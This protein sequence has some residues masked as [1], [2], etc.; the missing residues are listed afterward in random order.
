[1]KGCEG[2]KKLWCAV[3]VRGIRYDS[4]PCKVLF[5]VL[6]ARLGRGLG[7]VEVLSMKPSDPLQVAKDH[8]GWVGL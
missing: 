8:R 3:C 2:R 6:F 5:G 4:F 1:M 7:L